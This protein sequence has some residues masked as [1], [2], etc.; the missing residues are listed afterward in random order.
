MLADRWFL[1]FLLAF[2]V[3]QRKPMASQL[4]VEL[5]VLYF[6]SVRLLQVRQEVPANLV[7]D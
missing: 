1:D 4:R 3:P 7:I 5:L 2:E 6:G